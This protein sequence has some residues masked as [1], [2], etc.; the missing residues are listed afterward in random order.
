MKKFGWMVFL[1]IFLVLLAGIAKRLEDEEWAEDPF[2]F[3]LSTS[4]GDANPI[5]VWDDGKMYYVFLPSY[6]R[7]DQ[8]KPVISKNASVYIDGHLLTNEQHLSDL[9]CDQTYEI[10]IQGKEESEKTA[11]TFL[12][13]ENTATI[14]L[15]TKSGT[16]D[17]IHSDKSFK[18]KTL[19]TVV[20]SSG[21][22]EFKDKIGTLKGRG[23]ASW[24]SEKK[25]YTWEFSSEDELLGLSSAKKWNLISNTVD[26]TNL[27]NIL[28]F[29]LAQAVGMWTP[30]YRFADLYINGEY[31]GL[32]LLTEKV[33]IGKNRLNIMSDG[34]L[35]LKN[36]LFKNEPEVRWHDLVQPMRTK[37]GRV[38]V[39]SDPSKTSTVRKKQILEEVDRMEDAIQADDFDTIDMESWVRKYLIEEISA[40]P[41][42][43]L[44]S[45]YFYC[46]HT[47]NGQVFY[48]GPPWDYDQ[49]YGNYATRN[50]N[51]RALYAATFAESR[52]METPYFSHLYHNPQ[53]YNQVIKV[54][55]KD[56]LP[57][58]ERM[59]N[60]EIEEVEKRIFKASQMNKIRWYDDEEE[61]DSTRVL[62]YLKD[63]VK[64]LNEIWIDQ[65]EYCTVQ[66]EYAYNLY[67]YTCSVKK[68]E[69]LNTLWGRDLDSYD[70]VWIDAETGER[71]DPHL[72]ILKDT[73]L[74]IEREPET[75]D[76]QET[77][78]LSN[79]SVQITLLSIG[80]MLVLLMLL[81]CRSVSSE[82]SRHKRGVR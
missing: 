60:G 10:T 81:I 82:S 33:E 65:A 41:D 66:I 80:G 45:S 48:A 2:Y 46:I 64:F 38:F 9:A 70:Q 53:F 16:L 61:I 29:N 68:G 4:A 54:Y 49:A 1:A 69:T 76:A 32:Y 30:G 26:S 20:D 62:N 19:G 71:F 24:A 50:A 3:L 35:S 37:T 59:L 22:Q 11:I 34:K 51:P 67:Y 28:T 21:E 43:D 77:S 74:H 57:V 31:N 17:R 36:Y 40:N 44:A 27:R 15:D 72:P 39:I 12:Q 52:T 55:K 63:R 56:F 6:A 42:A 73:V 14:F 79:R 18:E 78:M 58:L 5:K 8:L 13:S 75:E 7:F 25:S 23:Q 47:E